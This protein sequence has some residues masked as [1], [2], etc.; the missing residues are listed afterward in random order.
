MDFLYS[1]QKTITIDMSDLKWKESI[2]YLD[3]NI[4]GRIEGY[5]GGREAEFGFEKSIFMFWILKEEKELLHKPRPL[6]NYNNHVYFLYDEICSGKELVLID[7]KNSTREKQ[8][9]ANS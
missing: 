1:V 8:D 6:Q 9:L 2:G 4:I 3:E 7:S 5:F